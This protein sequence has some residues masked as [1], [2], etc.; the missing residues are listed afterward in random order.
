MTYKLLSIAR[1][2][3]IARDID[4]R[5]YEQQIADF[6]RKH[7]VEETEIIECQY[8]VYDNGRWQ[9]TAQVSRFDEWW[10]GTIEQ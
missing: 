10:M 5:S 4:G 3:P 7:G 6:D 1:A 8:E 2:L 9:E